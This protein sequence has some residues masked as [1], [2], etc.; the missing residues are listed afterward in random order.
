MSPHRYRCPL[1]PLAQD[2]ISLVCCSC[3]AENPVGIDAVCCVSCRQLFCDHCMW[4][5]G[6]CVIDAA[7]I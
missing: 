5:C 7:P 1:A 6:V 2:R 4:V 3:K